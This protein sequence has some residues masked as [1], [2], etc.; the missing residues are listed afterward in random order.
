MSIHTHLEPG[1]QDGLSIRGRDVALV[2]DTW[3][4]QHHSSSG[5]NCR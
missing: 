2:D 4:E 3:P 5:T 1:C